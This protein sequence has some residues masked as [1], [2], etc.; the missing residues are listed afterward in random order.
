MYKALVYSD[1]HWSSYSSIL[2]AREGKYSVRLNGLIKSMNYI[3]E[4]AVNNNC[5]ELICCGDFYDR[6]SISCEEM[7]AL[8]DIKFSGL[9]HI[10]LVGNHESDVSSLDFS[11]TKFFESINS[12]VIDKY[13]TIKIND[14]VNFTFIPYISGDVPE[15]SNFIEDRDKKNVVFAHQEIAGI[16]YGK[17]V[18][19]SGF[20]IDDIKNNCNLFLDGHLHNNSIIDRSIV[21]LGNLTGQNFNEDSTRY[22]HL[23]YILTVEDDGSIILEPHENPYAFNFYKIKIENKSDIDQLFRLKSNAVLSVVCN[24]NFTEEVNNILKTLGNVVTYR[25]SVIYLDNMS[26]DSDNSELLNNDNYIKRFI[27]FAQLKLQ[28]SPALIDELSRF[29]EI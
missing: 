17:V 27:D 12:T 1:V 13:K 10:F 16:S 24:S 22:K 6:P 28:H 4:Y 21:I 25:L 11:S 23:F 29:G 2:R 9:H 18:S 15:L 14:L 20:K 3:E 7:T 5:D 26:Y 19:Q 8:Q